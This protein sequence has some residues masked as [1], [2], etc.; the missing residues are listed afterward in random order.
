MNARVNM[1]HTLPTGPLTVTPLCPPTTG[2]TTFVAYDRSPKS[3][4]TKVEART[5]SNVVTPN[6]L[7]DDITCINPL[8]K[9]NPP[10]GV[11]NTMLFEH[12]RNDGHS[13]IDRVRNDKHKGLGCDF[14]NSCC[15]ISHDATIDLCG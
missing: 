7:S 6:I 3:S 8:R 1:S 2:M 4:A 15:Q 10:L 14:G 11:V 12:L 9:E 13:R 5:T